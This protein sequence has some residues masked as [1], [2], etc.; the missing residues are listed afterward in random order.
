MNIMHLDARFLIQVYLGSKLCPP[1]LETVALRVP[2]RYIKEFNMFNVWSS[3][4]N[5]P[6]ARY[7]SAVIVLYK[8]VDV[9]G[10]KIVLLIICYNW[11]FLTISY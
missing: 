10:T 4:K 1:V 7:A 3:S 9:F 11:Y 6:S 2:A 8:D 5:C